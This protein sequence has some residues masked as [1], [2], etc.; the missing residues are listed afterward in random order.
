MTG[1]PGQV[2]GGSLSVSSGQEGSGSAMTDA[3]EIRQMDTATLAQ[4]IKAKETVAS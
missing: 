1:L 2:C 3:N 4:R